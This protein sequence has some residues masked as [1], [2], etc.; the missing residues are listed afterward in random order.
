MRGEANKADDIFF[1][2]AIMALFLVFEGLKYEEVPDSCFEGVEFES[3]FEKVF[4][5]G[6][7]GEESAP[8]SEFGFP[9]AL[10][11]NVKIF[12]GGERCL[13]EGDDSREEGFFFS[14]GWFIGFV[15]AAFVVYF[16]IE[17]VVEED[18]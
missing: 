4:G 11:H 18:F 16:L 13:E 3:L 10:H 5:R 9:G 12:P 15:G 6:Q 7:V 17:D 8:G 14:E 2:S 1:D